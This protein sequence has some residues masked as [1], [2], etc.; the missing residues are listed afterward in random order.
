LLCMVDPLCALCSCQTQGICYNRVKIS[1]EFLLGKFC[2]LKCGCIYSAQ[3]KRSTCQE[4]AHAF[5]SL[6]QLCRLV[7][8]VLLHAPFIFY[9]W[10]NHVVFYNKCTCTFCGSLVRA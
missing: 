1:L 5:S 9:L 4:F 2:L 8:F 10:C 3:H 6:Q 7:A